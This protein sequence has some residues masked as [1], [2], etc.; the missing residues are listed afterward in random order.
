MVFWKVILDALLSDVGLSMV[1]KDCEVDITC[2]DINVCISS[3]SCWDACNLAVS[4]C[5]LHWVWWFSKPYI[6]IQ[7]SRF[8][9]L[10]RYIGIHT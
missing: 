4:S 1:G 5:T 9:K 8:N 3:V 6:N 7:K 10:H 2:G